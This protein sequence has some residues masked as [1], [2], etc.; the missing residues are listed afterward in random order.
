MYKTLILLKKFRGVEQDTLM[1]NQYPAFFIFAD[2]E[3]R[4]Y[5]QQFH[6]I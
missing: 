5:E 6:I 2:K 3:E 1:N 4:Y